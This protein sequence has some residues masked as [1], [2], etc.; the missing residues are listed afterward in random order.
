MKI[1]KRFL[2]FLTAILLLLPLTGCLVPKDAEAGDP[3]ANDGRADNLPSDA[4][5]DRNAIAIELGDIRITAEEVEDMFYQYVSEFAYS[6]QMDEEMLQQVL[7]M[8]EEELIQYHMSE[9]KAKQLGITLS[10]EQEAVCAASAQKYVDNE[11]DELIL[12]Y[13][14]IDDTVAEYSQLSDEQRTN[15]IDTINELLEESYGEGYTFDDY[16]AAVYNSCLTSYRSIQFDELLEA[17]FNAENAVDQSEIDEWYEDALAEQE[18]LYTETP[19]EFLYAMQNFVDFGED[20]VLFAPAETA[21]LELIHIVGD[22]S[23]ETAISE[24]DSKMAELEAEYGK[25]ALSGEDAARRSEIETEY[26]KLKAESETLKAQKSGGLLKTAQEI[27]AK[28]DG[29]MSFADAMSA[30]NKNE[31]TADGAIVD[32]VFTDGSE[33]LKTEFAEAAKNLTVG[34]YSEPISVGSDYYIIRLVEI[35]P[36]GVIDRTSIEDMLNETV[37]GL[38]HADAWSMQYDAWFE[39]AKTAAVYHRETYDM[40]VSMYLG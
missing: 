34:A 12:V 31:E 28:L 35:I 21:R 40:L 7:R 30:Y 26:A 4:E 23:N 36:A 15:G 18:T 6:Y 19:E 14:G 37:P 39:E 8:T 27:H 25:L 1:Q 5:F 32:F 3:A 22:G 9:W 29:G 38:L 2:A 33:T 17:Q 10:E 20:P 11:R 16:L 24:N 13:S